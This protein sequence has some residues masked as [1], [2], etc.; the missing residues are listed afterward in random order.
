[1]IAN[2]LN[3][4]KDENRIKQTYDKFREEEKRREFFTMR[5]GSTV[6]RTTS[7]K[8]LEEY[9]KLYNHVKTKITYE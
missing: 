6:I 4:V 2:T 3:K 8:R 5:I 7:R 9:A 1:M